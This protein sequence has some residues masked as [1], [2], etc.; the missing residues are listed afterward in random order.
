MASVRHEDHE[1]GGLRMSRCL[2]TK[3]GQFWELGPDLSR[4]LGLGIVP[5]SKAV[6]CKFDVRRGTIMMHGAI[7]PE[8]VWVH[9]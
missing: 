7:I 5:V 8:T 3:Q 2:R 9:G 4:S 1:R 6:G